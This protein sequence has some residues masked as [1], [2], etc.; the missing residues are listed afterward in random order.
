M[1]YSMPVGLL[2]PYNSWGHMR[3]G[4]QNRKGIWYV[5]CGWRCCVMLQVSVDGISMPTCQAVET[6]GRAAHPCMASDG[7]FCYKWTFQDFTSPWQLMR[8][9]SNII[10][11]KVFFKKKAKKENIKIY[12]LL[13]ILFLHWT[14]TLKR[15]VNFL[16]WIWSFQITV[17]CK[18]LN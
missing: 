8:I 14:Y 10:L 5:M 9:F 18:I 16:H 12:I 1:C 2:S 7:S 17:P 3:N 6:R 4:V 15:Q 13:A 11:K